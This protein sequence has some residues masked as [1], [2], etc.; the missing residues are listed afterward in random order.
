LKQ[1]ESVLYVGEQHD[2]IRL[3]RLNS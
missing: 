3:E 1:V 2:A